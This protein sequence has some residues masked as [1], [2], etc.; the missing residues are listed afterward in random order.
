MSSRFF[1][2]LRSPGRRTFLVMLFVTFGLCRPGDAETLYGTGIR[3]V[4]GDSFVVRVEGREIE[5]RLYGIDC[6]EYSQP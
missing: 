5:V 6:P 3:V 4:D 1:D 2:F